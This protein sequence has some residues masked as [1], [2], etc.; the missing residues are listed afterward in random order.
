MQWENVV[1]YLV[2]VLESKWD[3]F[4]FRNERISNYTSCTKSEL[5]KVQSYKIYS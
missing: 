2:I 3:T 1:I 5:L 4:Y